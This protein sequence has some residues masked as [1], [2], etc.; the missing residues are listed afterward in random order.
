M[1]IPLSRKTERKLSERR[2][3]LKVLGK[4]SFLP[5]YR[6]MRR[7]VLV[8]NAL[9]Y[10]RSRRLARALEQFVAAD[11]TT[12]SATEDFIGGAWQ[13]YRVEHTPSGLING[14]QQGYA[15]T[16]LFGTGH[17]SGALRGTVSPN[18]LDTSSAIH[19]KNAEG[20]TMRAIIPSRTAATAM[21]ASKLEGWRSAAGRSR[22][23]RGYDSELLDT[24]TSHVIQQFASRASLKGSLIHIETIDAI[25]A[26]CETPIEN[27][28]SIW[29]QGQIIEPGVALV[30][31]LTV[32]DER[33]VFLPTGFVKALG[34]TVEHVLW[35]APKPMRIAA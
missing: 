32:N 27:R 5:R 26:S 12:F 33:R 31:A 21:I 25:D 7:E 24:H 6:R 16:G 3:R 15:S 9:D 23:W 35:N 29:L 28:P 8:E 18:L 20:A 34:G 2:L 30:T 14:S 1:T 22:F 13:P 17:Y 4:F 10:R 19:L 11:V